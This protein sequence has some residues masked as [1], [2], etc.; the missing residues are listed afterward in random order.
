MITMKTNKSV[1]IVGGGIG[2]YVQQLDFSK[3]AIVWLYMEKEPLVGGR[4]NRIMQ[5]GY[6]FDTGPTLL[7][8]TDILYDTFEYCGKNLTIT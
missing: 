6:T 2:A 7:M 8:M 4:A 3:V 1:V 5:D